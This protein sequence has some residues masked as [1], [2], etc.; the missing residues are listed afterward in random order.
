MRAVGSRNPLVPNSP[1]AGAT[2]HGYSVR[3]LFASNAPERAGR[4]GHA[5]QCR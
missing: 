1:H 2:S 4:S 5:E 3:E